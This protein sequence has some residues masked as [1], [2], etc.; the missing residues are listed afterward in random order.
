MTEAT[1]VRGRGD[2]CGVM[3]VG[4]RQLSARPSKS[5][6]EGIREMRQVTGRGESQLDEKKEQLEYNRRREKR[7]PELEAELKWKTLW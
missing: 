2:H 4:G 5:P 1:V 3:M 7:R 6:R